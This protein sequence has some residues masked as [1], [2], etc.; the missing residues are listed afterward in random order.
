MSEFVC[1]GAAA[2]LAPGQCREASVGG[3]SVALF[4]VGGEIR[5]LSNRCSHRGGPLGQ[6]YLDG[7]TIICPW[8]GWGFDTRTGQ[9]QMGPEHDVRRFA[10]RVEDGQVFVAVEDRP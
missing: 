9:S 5:A 6:G 2:D 3:R 4:N 8:H 1:V 10:V 7:D